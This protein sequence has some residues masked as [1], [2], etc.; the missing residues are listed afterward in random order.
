MEPKT[1]TAAGAD[2]KKILLSFGKTIATATLTGTMVRAIST[3]LPNL[4]HLNDD[5]SAQVLQK[6]EELQQAEPKPQ[7][8]ISET[9]VASRPITETTTNQHHTVPPDQ[10]QND[11]STGETQEQKAPVQEDAEKETPPTVSEATDMKDY[12]AEGDIV[13]AIAKSR[14]E[15][16]VGK[17]IVVNDKVYSNYTKEEFEAMPEPQQIEFLKNNIEFTSNEQL[18]NDAGG[19]VHPEPDEQP[20]TTEDDVQTTELTP[21]QIQTLAQNGQITVVINNI[22]NTQI[23]YNGNVYLNAPEVAEQTHQEAQ[24]NTDPDSEGGMQPEEQTTSGEEN[25][26]PTQQNEQEEETDP[27]G[28]QQENTTQEEQEPQPEEE[29]TPE[30][31]PVEQQ[32][33]SENETGT[34]G[35]LPQLPVEGADEETPIPEDVTTKPVMGDPTDIDPDTTDPADEPDEEPDIFDNPEDDPFSKY[36]VD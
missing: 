34:D 22:N 36:D 5:L 18:T 8:V 10:V 25:T 6:Q 23:T 33:S 29:P 1:N 32:P 27:A 7:P 17:L 28:Q 35:V 16:G 12:S 20:T 3:G 31:A 15:L 4:L 26:D 19:W 14:E 24:V 2:K 13:T 30:P 11:T 21:E 9:D